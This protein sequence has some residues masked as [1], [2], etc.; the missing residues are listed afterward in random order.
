MQS[1]RKRVFQI[2]RHQTEKDISDATDIR[3]YVV[4]ELGRYWPHGRDEILSLPIIEEKPLD[5]SEKLLPPRMQSVALP[6]WASDVGVDKQLLVPEHLIRYGDLPEWQR[7]DWIRVVFWY[8]NG[9]AER[10]FEERHGPVHSYS[11]RLKGWDSRLWEHAWVNRIALFLRRWA[12]KIQNTD[13]ISLFG[14]LPEP[15]IIITHDLDAVSKTLAIRCKQSVFQIFKV[16]KNLL[17]GQFQASSRESRKALRFFF[18][19][20]NYDHLERLTKMEARMGL[21]SYIN[22]Y[23]GP[24]GWRRTPKQ[25]LFDPG[26]SIFDEKLSVQLRKLHDN[27]WIIGLHQSFDAWKSAAEMGKERTKIEQVTGITVKSC[28]QHWLRFSWADTWKAQQTAGLEMDFTLGFNDR[29]GFRNGSALKFHPWDFD[30]LKPMNLVSIPLAL[31]DSQLYDYSC[32]TE[33]EVEPEV[34]YWIKEIM[35]TRGTASVLW[36]PHTLSDDYGWCKGFE[37]VLKAVGVN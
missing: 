26:Y 13:E 4:G 20:D 7:V 9:L 30:S 11:S 8:L 22:A 5:K 35:V 31:A 2:V 17:S 33:E 3:S 6:D 34:N 10:F 23:G 18:G 19:S 1:L 37:S 36:H 15:E 29:P 32:L 21:R 27:G 25:M 12:A 24:G 16:V 14:L 28:R